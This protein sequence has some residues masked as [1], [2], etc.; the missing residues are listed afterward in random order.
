MQGPSY[1]H[2]FSPANLP[3]GLVSSIPGHEKPQAATRVGD[4]VIFLS[5]PAKAG[6]FADVDGLARGVFVLDTLNDFAALPRSVHR[7]VRRV[8]QALLKDER[9]DDFPARL[10]PLRRFPIRY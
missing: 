7:G 3:F 10:A 5:D 1:G 6:L 8:L 4:T 2:H 9:L